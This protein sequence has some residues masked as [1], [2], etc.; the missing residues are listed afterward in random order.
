[1]TDCYLCPSFAIAPEYVYFPPVDPD[2]EYTDQLFNTTYSNVESEI[3]TNFSRCVCEIGYYAI[4]YDDEDL[5][6]HFNQAQGTLPRGLTLLTTLFLLDLTKRISLVIALYYILCLESD[7]EEFDPEMELGFL[8]V[9]CPEGRFIP[10][11]AKRMSSSTWS[12]TL[13]NR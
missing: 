9:P 3:R 1:M 10:R 4:P 11:T 12:G 7:E 6:E 8:C 13:S 5:L 2:K